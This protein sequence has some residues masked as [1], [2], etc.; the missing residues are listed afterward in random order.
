MMK[1]ETE[2]DDP[3]YETKDAV[4]SV[5]LALISLEGLICEVEHGWL[6]FPEK[7]K[8][9]ITSIFA[10]LVGITVKQTTKITELKA[11][12]KKA[13]V[14]LKQI[15]WECGCILTQGRS[16]LKK[17]KEVTVREGYGSKCAK[18]EGMPGTPFHDDCE[19]DGHDFC[20]CSWCYVH[21]DCGTSRK[22]KVYEDSYWSE[23][24]DK[25]APVDSKIA[26]VKD[27]KDDED[28]AEMRPDGTEDSE[29]TTPLFE[30][31]DALKPKGLDSGSLP[32]P[33][34]KELKVD[35]KPKGLDSGS[36]PPPDFEEMKVDVKPKGLDS[37]SR[38]TEDFQFEAQDVSERL[39]YADALIEAEKKKEDEEAA[40]AEAARLAKLEEERLE[41]EA[42]EKE[43]EAKKAA[44]EAKKALDAKAKEEALEKERLAKLEEERLEK[45]AL[46]KEEE[47][48]KAAELAAQLAAEEEKLQT[49]RLAKIKKMSAAVAACEAELSEKRLLSCEAR[50]RYMMNAQERKADEARLEECR[51]W[52]QVGPSKKKSCAAK[53]TTLNNLKAAR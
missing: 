11:R 38:P 29:E 34:F 6:L 40:A 10:T 45:E 51:Y 31:L 44:E 21:A 9:E 26:A 33:D 22:S 7:T 50:A 17:F 15:D 5:W 47:A 1:T 43:L 49:E 28:E 4:Q 18:W 42:A 39:K 48:K 24:H 23:C 12:Y 53:K 8:E 14:Y 13:V 36:R 3:S 20:G 46:A 2:K 52:K 35:V 37:G 41:R 32:P 19:K 25:D 27:V 16:P 30:P